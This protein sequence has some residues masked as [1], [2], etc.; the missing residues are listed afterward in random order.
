MSLSTSIK[1]LTYEYDLGV[2]VPNLLI[3]KN[4]ARFINV[5]VKNT[6]PFIK[7]DARFIDTNYDFNAWQLG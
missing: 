7:S 3:I 4:D 1:S 6:K 2:M 5:L